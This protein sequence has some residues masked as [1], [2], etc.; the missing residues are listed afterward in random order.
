MHFKFVLLAS[1]KVIVIGT[2]CKSCNLLFSP[3]LFYWNNASTNLMCV[4]LHYFLWLEEN[5][6][7]NVGLLTRLLILRNHKHDY[8]S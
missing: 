5:N 8:Y 6:G 4:D 2:T 7:P 1:L 3:T